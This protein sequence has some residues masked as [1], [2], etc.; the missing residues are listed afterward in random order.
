MILKWL[1]VEKKENSEVLADVWHYIDKVDEV[2][3]RWSDAT[4]GT[5]VGLRIHDAADIINVAVTSEAYLLSDDGK[6]VERI[7]ATNPKVIVHR[8]SKPIPKDADDSK[9]KANNEPKIKAK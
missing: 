1:T 6:T 8:T 5:V 3:V 4:D 9:T 2:T 7:V